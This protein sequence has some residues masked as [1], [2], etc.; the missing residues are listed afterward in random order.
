M[1]PFIICIVTID[2]MEKA[3]LIARVLVEK[4]L[5]AC[6]NIVP[7]IRSIYSWKGQ[8]YD[9]SECL[10]IMKTR[11]ELFGKL[12]TAAKELH[13][14]EVPEIIAL[15]IAE[16]LPAYLSWIDESTRPKF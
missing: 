13:P 12:Q 10:M 3:A 15:E 8:I 5:V 4:K 14:Y 6:V 16:G 9:E 7:Q 1:N 2:D 11:R